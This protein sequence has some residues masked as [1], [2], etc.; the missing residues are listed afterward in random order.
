MKIR[1]EVPNWADISKDLPLKNIEIAHLLDS[2]TISRNELINSSCIKMANFNKQVY[3]EKKN[4][5][6]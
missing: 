2:L 5:Y 3:I 1:E 6:F 4:Y